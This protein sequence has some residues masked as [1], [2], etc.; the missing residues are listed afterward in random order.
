MNL[1]EFNKRTHFSLFLILLWT[2]F[3]FFDSVYFDQQFFDGKTITTIIVLCIA[4]FLLWTA[5]LR[6]KILMFI[7]I[8]LSW[9]G[10]YLFSDLFDMYD[11]RDG[12]IPFYVPFGHAGVYTL[13]WLLTQKYVTPKNTE[14]VKKI[15]GWFYI[16]AFPFVIFILKDTLSLLLGVLFFFALKRK[17]FLPFYLVMGL[18]VLYLELIGTYLEVWKWHSDQ[19]IFHTVNPPLGA[20]FLYVGGDLTLNK[21][22]RFLLKK[23]R[24]IAQNYKHKK[25]FTSVN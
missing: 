25:S 2:P 16:I 15:V 20:I 24:K 7:M 23:R 6:L 21:L 5:P 1:I 9:F 11:Y 14:N 22:T 8:P 10:E 13:G 17:N 12:T 19:G 4:A 18:L 3:L